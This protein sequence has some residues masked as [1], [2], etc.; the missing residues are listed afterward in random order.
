MYINCLLFIVT[1]DNMRKLGRQIT[2]F[3]NVCQICNTVVRIFHSSLTFFLEKIY[4]SNCEIITLIVS[5][6]AKILPSIIPNADACSAML[7]DLNIYMFFFNNHLLKCAPRQIF[8]DVP[9]T[10]Q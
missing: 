6:V 3:K 1:Y 2:H 5:N 9:P 10:S 7:G 4:W 8:L